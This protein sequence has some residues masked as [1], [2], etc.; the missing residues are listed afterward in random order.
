LRELLEKSV[1]KTEEL[2]GGNYPENA[3]QDAIDRSALLLK[4]HYW[5]KLSA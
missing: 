2:Y 3:M 4:K 5:S 1:A